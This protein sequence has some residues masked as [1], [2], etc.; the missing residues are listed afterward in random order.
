MRFG[1]LR[2]H[3]ISNFDLSVLKNTKIT[4]KVNLAVQG[5][6]PECLQHAVVVYY[7]DPTQPDGDKFLRRHCGHSGELRTA[8]PV[9]HEASL[10]KQVT[11]LFP[12]GIGR[13][14]RG[15]LDP[16]FSSRSQKSEIRG[17]ISDSLPF[18]A[19][20]FVVPSLTDDRIST[21]QVSDRSMPCQTG[22]RDSKRET[23]GRF[24][25]PMRIE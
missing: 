20:F 17:L 18:S 19:F 2:A 21:C 9:R 15:T 12:T 14:D 5:G 11:Q 7:A 1:F 8:N 23:S 25:F 22:I 10:L 16:L 6:V 4:E 24:Q 13:P 3:N